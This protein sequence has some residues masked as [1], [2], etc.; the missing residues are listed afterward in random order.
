MTDGWN[1]AATTINAG[2]KIQFENSFMV[3]PVNGKIYADKA[4]FTQLVDV[5]D[6]TGAITLTL[7]PAMDASPLSPY[8]NMSQ[9]PANDAKVYVW[10]KTD[11]DLD[12]ISGKNGTAGILMHKSALV[13]ASPELELPSDV[14]RL[15]GRTRSE[16]M[17]IAIRIW[18]ASDIKSGQRITRFDILCGFLVPQHQRACLIASA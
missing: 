6:A 2:D 11:S 5:S 12:A 15:S 16:R 1:S 9:L 7:E 3:H 18:R 17:N 8:R 14:D 10:G 13:Y 4:S